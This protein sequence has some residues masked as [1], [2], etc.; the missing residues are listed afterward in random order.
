VTGN[1]GNR[2]AWVIKLTSNGTLA[3]QKSLGGSALDLATSARLT[4]DGGFIVAGESASNDGDVSFNHGKRDFWL[5]KLT[6]DGTLEW[7]K[8]LG[9]SFEDIATSA[10]QTM[11]PQKPI[12]T[13]I[14]LL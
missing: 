4:S 10:Q 9:G 1:H 3:W 13:P 5:V 7:E 8:C 6:P 11:A 12:K 2:D 14:K